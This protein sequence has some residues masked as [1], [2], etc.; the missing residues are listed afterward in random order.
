[1]LL[2]SAL[3][4]PCSPACGGQELSESLCLRAAVL[5]L[6]SDQSTK[7]HKLP[8]ASGRCSA[9]WG[10]SGCCLFLQMW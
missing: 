3:T 10:T 2:S 6:V 1:M 8:Q 4:P 9:T 5:C 7:P